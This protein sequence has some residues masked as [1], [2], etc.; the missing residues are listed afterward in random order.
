MANHLRI[1]LNLYN[2]EYHVFKMRQDGHMTF[3]IL[4]KNGNVFLCDM[5]KTFFNAGFWKIIFKNQLTL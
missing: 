1:S 5:K 2:I 4:Q 3:G